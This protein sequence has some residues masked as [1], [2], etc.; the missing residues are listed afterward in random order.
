MP[1]TEKD[2]TPAELKAIEDHK[3]FMSLEKKEEVSIDDAIKDFLEKYEKAWRRDKLRSDNLTQVKEIEKHK[4]IRSQQEG[5]DL[6][7]DAAFE[8]AEKYAV[9]WREERESLERNG[10]Y[11][12]ETVVLN[13]Q[14]LHMRPSSTLA[15]I[16]RKY[17]CDI[18]IHK[19]GMDHYNFIMKGRRYLNVK[20]ILGLLTLGVAKGDHLEFLATGREAIDALNAINV[21][22]KEKLREEESSEEK[23]NEVCS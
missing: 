19:E 12:I 11:N 5:H 18:Y 3:Y 15:E 4:W 1:I 22:I 14:G 13:S 20:S 21:M 9:I 6:G 2:L 23:P 17:D 16:A 7:N 8:W 10:F